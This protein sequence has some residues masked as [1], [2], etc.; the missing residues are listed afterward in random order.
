MSGQ[1]VRERRPEGIDVGYVARLARLDLTPEET[2]RFQSQLE[3][4]VGYVRQIEA[5]DVAGVEPTSHAVAVTNV[6]RPDVARPGLDHDTVMANA[7]E[8]IDG[9]FR[10]PRIVDA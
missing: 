1:D 9:H 2:A 6:L 4:I 3:H 5:L 10:V 8:T 7:P